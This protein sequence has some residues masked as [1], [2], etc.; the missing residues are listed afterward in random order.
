M[1]WGTALVFLTVS[2]FIIYM[3]MRRR[4]LTGVQRVF[5]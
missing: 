5:W 1:L 4:N 3:T 2:G